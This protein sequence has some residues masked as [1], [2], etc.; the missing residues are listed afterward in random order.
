MSANFAA[1]R[2]SVPLF[3]YLSAQLC[4]FCKTPSAPLPILQFCDYCQLQLAQ[5]FCTKLNP[6]VITAGWLP[7]NRLCWAMAVKL[8]IPTNPPC[9]LHYSMH[10]PF[11][12]ACN[13]ANCTSPNQDTY[14]IE[15]CWNHLTCAPPEHCCILR[16]MTI[17]DAACCCHAPQMHWVWP[18]LRI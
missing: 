16:A 13:F 7:C 3:M 11:E 17:F 6:T 14:P 4:T 5:N 15:G 12:N 9:G 2:E 1:T 10:M 8:G 18:A